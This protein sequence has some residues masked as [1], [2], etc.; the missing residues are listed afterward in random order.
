MQCL[1]NLS[2]RGLKR[3]FSV[4]FFLLLFMV[5]VSENRA[6]AEKNNS[7]WIEFGEQ[8]KE[9]DGSV[10]QPL[11]IYY[12]RFPDKKGSPLE[13]EVCRAGYTL[14]RKDKNGENIF[15]PAA[16]ESVNGAVTIRVNAVKSDRYTVLAE[17]ERMFGGA[18]YVYLAK[19]SFFLFGHSPFKRKETK[20]VLS[21]EIIERLKIGIVP[22]HSVWLQTGVPANFVLSFDKSIM[23]EKKVCIVD[24]NGSFTEMR[25]DK[26]GR[27]VYV[28]PDDEKLNYRGKTAYKQVVIQTE[29][30]RKNTIFKSSCTLLFH[31]SR[32]GKRSFL[33]GVSILAITI[34][35][36]FTIVGIK[37]RNSWL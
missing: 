20:P 25:V 13:L 4:I 28:S 10:T 18:R 22:E 29:E 17:A 35:V 1:G 23:A 6:F 5:N 9:K 15:Y 32:F 11:F 3:I 31:P 33:F 37:R 14:N 24:E 16:F 21:N 34:A 7:L 12:G 19:A 8:I 26:E 2:M 36:V 27:A 30:I